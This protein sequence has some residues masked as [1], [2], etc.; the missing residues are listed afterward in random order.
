MA[1]LVGWKTGLA[2]RSCLDMR[3]DCSTCHNSS[4]EAITSLA[5]VTDGGYCSRSVPGRPD[6]GRGRELNR[7]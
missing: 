5:G 2:R 3:K 7:V 6:S 4:Y 1:S